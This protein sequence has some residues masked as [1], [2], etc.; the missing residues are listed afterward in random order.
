MLYKIIIT[1]VEEMTV[2]VDDFWEA[3]KKARD[4]A[5]ER[6]AEH[7]HG[8]RTSAIAVPVPGQK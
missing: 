2:E 5:N 4:I 6:N 1:T 7:H 8:E 3:N